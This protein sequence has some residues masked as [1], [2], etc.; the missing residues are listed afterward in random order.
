[1][2]ADNVAGRQGDDGAGVAAAVPDIDRDGVAVCVADA[3]VVTVAERVTDTVELGAGV[4]DILAVAVYEPL[5]DD[6]AADV[7]DTD[8]L[9]VG[10]AETVGL[11]VAV[12][13]TV[14]LL[15]AVGDAL[16]PVDGDDVGWEYVQLTT[17][18]PGCAE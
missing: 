15:V 9:T 3:G 8:V 16:A 14:R 6:V 7:F 2:A 12:A 4:T 13:E 1:M 5:T 17:R 11:T 18:R 10:V